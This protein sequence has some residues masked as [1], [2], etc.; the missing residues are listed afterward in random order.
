MKKK[1]K[2]FGYEISKRR[3]L[4][5]YEK[6]SKKDSFLSDKLNKSYVLN[7]TVKQSINLN[8][9]LFIINFINLFLKEKKKKNKYGKYFKNKRFNKFHKFNRLRRY[10]FFNN[11]KFK[12]FIKRTEITK[13]SKLFKFIKYVIFSRTNKINKNNFI[14]RLNLF[15]ELDDK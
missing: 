13:D 14:D 15:R 5:K 7:S 4:K 1:I 12:F 6:E 2:F 11:N 10:N 9:F 8:N 3:S